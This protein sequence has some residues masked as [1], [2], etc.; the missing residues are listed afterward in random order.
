[1]AQQFVKLGKAER[2]AEAGGEAAPGFSR[3]ALC[4]CIFRGLD[5]FRSRAADLP[6]FFP[7]S[8][9]N[10]NSVSNSPFPETD[11]NENEKFN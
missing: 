6:S 4:E 10:S 11:A 9:A 2:A 8:S 7:S 3:K 1:M 5:S